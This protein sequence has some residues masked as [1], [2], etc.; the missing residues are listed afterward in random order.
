MNTRGP[1]DGFSCPDCGDGVEP[2]V[3]D[4]C[5]DCGGVLT[6]EYE[7]DQPVGSEGFDDEY[8]D[9]RRFAP[10]LPF[11]PS[12]ITSLGEGTTPLVTCPSLASE[13]DVADVLIKD[14]GRNP[15]G[16]AVDRGLSLAV[17]AAS[18][19][20]RA[21]VALPTTGHGGQSA[22]AY[23]GRAGL[24]SHS[25]VPTRSSHLTKAMINV[26]GGDMRVVEGRYPDA[27]EVFEEWADEQPETTASEGDAP[28]V[29]V[30]AASPFRREGAKLVVHEIVAELGESPPD[31]IV[32]PTGHG[33]GLAGAHAA[34]EELRSNGLLEKTPRLV[35]AQPE[36]CAPIV[37]AIDDA[38]G[39]GAWEHPDTIAGS[40]EIPAP[41][42]GREAV[43]AVAETEGHAVAVPDDQLLADAVDETAATGVEL[44][45]AGGVGVAGAR[46][47]ADRFDTD[48][49]V[50]VVNPVSGS[51]ESDVLRSEL[52]SRGE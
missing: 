44:G 5:P 24:D 19:R 11:E 38:D 23:A 47:L 37:R 52:M 34:I 15:T 35:A 18:E 27:A 8:A 7:H 40:L 13:L 6:I 45:L 28:W 31:V 25:F 9:Q 43:A 1:V 12:L 17:T 48:D 51:K 29:A 26:H 2:T 3:A 41:A 32:V 42:R 10:F 39:F 36:G 30:D 14:E 22:A 21:T 16:A 50:V 49:T 33:V 46:S 20:N 4:R